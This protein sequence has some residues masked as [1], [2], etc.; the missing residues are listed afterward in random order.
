MYIPHA[1][2]SHTRSRRLLHRCHVSPTNVA[3][4]L[5]GDEVAARP[6]WCE[7]DASALTHFTFRDQ[8]P[9]PTFESAYNKVTAFTIADKHCQ[10]RTCATQQCCVDAPSWFTPRECCVTTLLP[11]T[12]SS[13]CSQRTLH[14][15]GCVLGGGREAAAPKHSCWCDPSC[16]SDSNRIA[17]VRQYSVVLTRT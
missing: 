9:C 15:W 2:E 5:T 13:S 8:R 11:K 3:G 6:A 10:P 12:N 1:R 17:A 4:R 16:C 7:R 14:P